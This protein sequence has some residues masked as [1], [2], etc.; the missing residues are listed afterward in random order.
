LVSHTKGRT[1]IEEIENKVLRRTFGSK[2]EEVVGGWRRLHNGAFHNLYVSPN[3]IR[4][5]K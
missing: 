2:E 3:D 5:I 4:V 1:Q